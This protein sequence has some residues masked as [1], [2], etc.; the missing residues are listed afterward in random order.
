MHGKIRDFCHFWCQI[1][2][3]V[4]FSGG[5]MPNGT[6]GLAKPQRAAWHFRP[7]ETARKI[8]RTNIL[9]F[10]QSPLI[11]GTVLRNVAEPLPRQVSISYDS[12]GIY[13]GNLESLCQTRDRRLQA[14]HGTSL[15]PALWFP[16]CIS[17]H[18]EHYGDPQALRDPT[19]RTPDGV[20]PDIGGARC[21]NRYFCKLLQP[22][23]IDGRIKVPHLSTMAATVCKSGDPHFLDS[24]GKSK[25]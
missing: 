19:T 16:P 15:Q 12:N 2:D 24:V 18:L 11:I 9:D 23:P 4:G 22:W 5:K 21:Y 8:I 14:S 1:S 13:Y 25:N 6:R 3:S 20:F 17:R 7:F 10:R